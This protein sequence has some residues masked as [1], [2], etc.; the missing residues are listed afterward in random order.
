MKIHPA[1]D[2]HLEFWH[3]WHMRQVAAVPECDVLVL[4]GDILTFRMF[5]HDERAEICEAFAAKAKIVF[6]VPGNHEFYGASVSKANAA[7]RDMEASFPSNMKLIQPDDDHIHVYGG[8]RFL[9]GT[10]WFPDD[11]SNLG[12]EQFLGDFAYIS[13]FKPWVYEEN[14]RTKEFIDKNV[15]AGD[16]VV[17]H[18]LPSQESVGQK[19]KRSVLNRFFVSP[20]DDIISN[21]KPALWLHGHTHNSCDYKHGDTRVVCNPMGYPSEVSEYTKVLIDLKEVGDAQ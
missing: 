16:V 4:V 8:R 20:C 10:L 21:G 3:P 2:M 14:R 13:D 9:G 15:C 6:Y 12:Y 7:L 19:Y 1:S 17:T 5:G 11:A 18:H